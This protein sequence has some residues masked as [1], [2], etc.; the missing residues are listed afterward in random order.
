MN[1]DKSVQQ[2]EDDVY[3]LYPES[4]G[5]VPLNCRKGTIPAG[6]REEITTAERQAAE[7]SSKKKEDHKCNEECYTR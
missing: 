5:H 1:M 2:M 7:G 6:I 3:K 4:E